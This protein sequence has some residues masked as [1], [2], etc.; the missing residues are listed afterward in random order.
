MK[1]LLFLIYKQNAL[2]VPF[3]LHVLYFSILQAKQIVKSQ[4]K[5]AKKTVQKNK[6]NLNNSTNTW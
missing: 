3:D 2:S 6:E 4:T 5:E 1:F